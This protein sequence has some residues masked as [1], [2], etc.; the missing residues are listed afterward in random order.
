V[1]EYTVLKHHSA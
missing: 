1:K